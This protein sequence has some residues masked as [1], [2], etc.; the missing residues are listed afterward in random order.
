MKLCGI[1]GW[2]GVVLV[3]MRLTTVNAAEVCIEP[4]PLL[5]AATLV[6][7]RA[8]RV[9]DAFHA[10]F[11]LDNRS[12]DVVEL[13]GRRAN[14][15]F[16][17]DYPDARIEFRDINGIWTQLLDHAAGTFLSSPSTLKAEKGSK[18]S[19]TNNR[20]FLR[21]PTRAERR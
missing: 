20:A 4:D 21:K 17:V 13:P 2:V 3:S 16:Y 7:K 18:V 10:E 9:D 14:G 15:K 11:E 1:V 12:I 6:L 5:P 8:E 19:L